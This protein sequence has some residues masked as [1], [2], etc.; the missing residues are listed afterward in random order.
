MVLGLGP[1]SRRFDPYMTEEME[2]W[3]S[4]V[5][6]NSLENCTASDGSRGSNPL[7]SVWNDGR[8]A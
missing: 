1:R 5:D 4:W 3:A 2:N 6:A 8:V 7:F